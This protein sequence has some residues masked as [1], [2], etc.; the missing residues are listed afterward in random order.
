[1]ADP[2]ALLTDAELELALVGARAEMAW[3]ASSA[4]FAAVVARRVAAAPA[5][6]RTRW[7]AWRV[8][9]ARV[10][11]SLVLAAAALLVLAAIVAAGV[12][13]LPGIRIVFG[14]LPSSGPEATPTSASASSPAAATATP[15]RPPGATLGL[16]RQVALADIAAGTGFEPR[17][18]ADPVVGGP[19][20]AAYLVDG[21]AS[22]VWAAGADLPETLDP[23]VGLILTQFQG[24][25]G[26]GY[27][28]KLVDNGTRLE[29]LTVGDGDGYWL[30]GEPHFLYYVDPSGDTRSEF[31]RMVGDVLI[32]SDGAVTY[33]LETALGKDA[34]V[35]IAESIE[36]G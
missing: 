9:P 14:P 21:R 12:L 7:S 23:G 19:P 1:M 28:E 13:G 26:Q 33:R 5:P 29:P 27:L 32:W 30:S 2:R 22:L 10:R 6:R 15:S 20:E 11:W 25:L 8:A 34:A 35:R 18:P 36:P 31:R 16:G 3:P 4:D 17:L 24:E